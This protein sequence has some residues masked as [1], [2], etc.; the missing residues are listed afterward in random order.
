MSIDYQDL[1]T[2]LQLTVELNS[3]DQI[4][5]LYNNNISLGVIFDNKIKEDISYTPKSGDRR[6]TVKEIENYL[7]AYLITTPAFSIY[8]GNLILLSDNQNLEPYDESVEYNPYYK[9][10]GGWKGVGTET[11]KIIGIFAKEYFE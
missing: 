8:L 11:N 10:M 4:A 7:K 1:S 9:F 6:K 5:I 2:F 3:H